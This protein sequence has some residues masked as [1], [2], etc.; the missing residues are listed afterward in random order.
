VSE[1]ASWLRGLLAERLGVAAD[2]I[3][4]EA[5]LNR[6]GLTSLTAA[7]IVT[8][9]EA[10][11]RRRLPPTLAWDYPTLERLTAFLEGRPDADAHVPIVPLAADD[12]IAIVGMAC[13]LPGASSLDDFW[14]LLEAGTDAIREVPADRWPIDQLYDADPLAPGR[15]ATR[16]GGF[17]E[18]VDRFDAAF[19]GLSPREAAQAD[20]QQRLALELAWEA[21]ED[22]AIR[23]SRLSGGRTGVF[24]GAMWSDYAR[25]LSGRD[26]I[27]QHTATGQDISIIS[28]RIAYTLGLQGP[29]LT[30]NTACSSALVAV[31]QAC[32]SLRSG[33]STVALAGGVHLVL[34][35][36]SSIAMTKFGAMAPDGRCKAF[37]SRANGYV[38]GEGGGIVVLKPLSAATRD[39]DRV[40]AVIRGSAVNNDGPS[41]GLTAPN[42]SAQRAMLRDALDSAH[43]H[44]HAVDYVEAHGTGTA[45]GDPIEAN[46]LAAVLGRDRPAGRALRIGSVKTNIGH[47]EAAAGAAGLIKTALALRNRWIP[48]SLHYQAPNPAIDFAAANLEVQSKGGAWPTAAPNPIAGVSSFGFGGTNSHVILQAVEP[49]ATTTS[50]AQA[51]TVFVFAGNGGNWA[52]MARGL[53]Q[54]PVF[55]AA[56]Q[57]C[58]RLLAEL[59]YPQPLLPVLESAQVTD[60]ALGQPALCAFQLALVDLL[61]T[62]GIKP[63]AVIGHSVGEAAAAITSGAL[64]RRD[65]LRLVLER[66]HLQASVAGQGGMALVSAAADAVGRHLPPGVTIAGENGPRATLIAGS[67]PSV[68]AACAV[69]DKAGILSLPIDVPVAYHSAQMD[70]LRP[71]LEQRLRDLKP[72]PAPIPMVSTVTGVATD[73]P[74]LDASYWGRNL[75]EPVRFRQGIETLVAA[76]YRAFVEI[77]AHPLLVP[78]IRQMTPGATVIA[79]LRRDAATSAAAQAALAPLRR[80]VGDGAIPRLLV[81]SARSASALEAL[82]R[83]WAAR[84]PAAW[85]EL[86][87]TAL[88]GRERFAHRLALWSLD[89]ETARRRLQTGDYR[90]GEASP[91]ATIAFDGTPRENENRESFLDRCAE[92]FVAGADLDGLA[93]P[94]SGIT[95]APTYPFERERHWLGAVDRGLSYTVDWETVTLPDTTWPG[96]SVEGDPVDSGLDAEA[97]A[98]AKAALAA[99]PAAEIAP[100]HR[101]LAERFAS[102]EPLA[103][104]PATEGA[105]RDLMRGVGE[106]LPDILAGHVQP[107]EVLFPGGA[108]DRAAAVYES[109]PFAAAQKALGAIIGK[110]GTRPLRI[111]EVGSGTGALTAQLLPSLPPGSTLVCSDLSVAFL[112]HLK[113]RFGDAAALQTTTFDLDKPEGAD[114]PFDAIVAA[115]VLHAT[116]DLD[117]AL[118]ALR[119]RLAPGGLLGLVELQRAPRWIDLVFGITEGWW[120]FHDDPNPRGHAVLDAE[121]WHSRLSAL[122]F[123]DVE[124]R[125]DGDAHAVVLARAPA[126]QRLWRP[127]A[128]TPAVLVDELIAQADD[129]TPLSIVH[130]TSLADAAVAGATRSLSL[131]HPALI[132]RSVELT[133]ESPRALAVLDAVLGLP[134]DEDQVRLTDGV[135]SVPRLARLT[136]AAAEASI[137]PDTLYIVAGGGGRLGQAMT[138]FLIDRGARHL[139][140]VGRSA[141]PSFSHRGVI[142]RSLALD[143]TTADAGARLRAAIDRPLGGLIHAA[144]VADGPTETVLATKLAIAAA[145][146]Q[147]AEGLSLGFLL[148][149]SSAA[150]IWGARGHVAY[151]AANRALDRWAAL[152]RERSVP[153]TSIGFGRFEERGLLSADEDRALQ[154]SG[155]KAMA[156]G[157][158]F[159]AALQAV[160]EGAAHRIVAAVD[161]PLFRATVEARRRRPFF[162]RVAPVETVTAKTVARANAA[163]P[164]KLDRTGLAALVADLLGHADASR[165]DPERGLFEQGLDSLLAVTLRRRLEEATGVAVPAA[166]L[167]AHPTLSLLGDWLGGQERVVPTAKAGARDNNEPIAIIGMGCRFAGGADTPAAYL[168][169]LM[170]GEDMVRQVP[171]TRPTAALWQAVPPTV[172]TAGFLDDVEKFDAAFFGL[173]PR[174]AAQLDP[175]Q[176][177]LLE[178]S[179]HA[180]EDARLSPKELN[181]RRAGV[182]VGATG[183]DYA[184]LARGL[185]GRALDAHS[186]VGQPSNT[187]AGRLAYQFG[188]H[189]PALTVDTACSSSL[190]ALHLAVNALRNGEADLAL[191]GG[192][193]LLLTPD[194]SLMLM[195]AGLLAPD[196]RCKVFDAGANGYVRGEGCGVIVLKPLG[197]ARRDGDRVL[198]VIRG[199]AV[200]HD[201]R[202]SSFTAP[203]GAAQAGVIRDALSNAGVEAESIDCIEAHG[204][205]TQLGDPIELDALADV[206]AGRQRPLLVGSVKAAIGHA[207]A[208][209]G[210]AA[211][212]KTVQSLRAGQLPPQPHFHHRNPHARDGSPV[213]VAA[214]GAVDARFAGV[215]AFGASGTNAHLVIERGDPLPANESAPLLTT[216]NRQVHWLAGQ[217]VASGARHPVLGEPRRSARS[218]ETVWETRLDPNADWLHDHV[219][220]GTILMPAA[221]FLDM[222]RRAG[223]ASLAD[224]EF[225]APLLVPAEGIAVQLV[226]DRETLTLYAETDEDWREIATARIASTPSVVDLPATIDAREID[227]TEIASELTARG[228]AFGP[229]YRTLGSLS[230]DAHHA[231]ATLE[232]VTE[233]EPAMLDAAIQTLTCLLPI[234]DIS[235]LPARIARVD[236]LQAAAAHSARARLL[237]RTPAQ[238][239]GD[240]ALH[241]AAGAPAVVLQGVEL[242]AA[243]AEP[244]AWFHDVLWRP[245]TEDGRALAGRWH[246]IG[247]GAVRP[248]PPCDG[249]VDLRPLTAR[250]PA[251]VVTDTV[252]LVRQALAQTPPP[253]LVLV[254][255]GASTS[256]PTIAQQPSAAAVLMGLQPVIASEHPE[257]S[258][259]WIDLDPDESDLPSDL[260]GE[261]G[262]YAI[263][264]GKLLSPDI[265]KA[266]S[267]P[268]GKIQLVPGAKGSFDDLHVVPAPEKALNAGE[269]R[270]AVSAVGL[271]FKDVLSVIGRTDESRLGLEAVGTVIATAPD[272]RHLATGDSVIAFGS[273]ALASEATFAGNQVVRRPPTLD[274]DTAASVAIAGLT[275]WYGLHDLAAIRPGMQ[276]LIHAG[277]GGVGGM[278]IQIA[279][280]AGARVFAT[281]SRGK[282]RL[283]LLNGAEA[284]G[285]SRSLDFV[286][287]A[288]GWCGPEGFDIV[289]NALGPEIADASARL[290]RP[291]GV[292]LEIGSAPNATG[293]RR[294]FTYDL[295]QAIRRDPNWFVD[296]MSKLLALLRDGK[297]APPRR[298]VLPLALTEEALR[299]LGQGRTVGKL[300]LK[301]PV[302]P[303]IHADASYLVTGGTGD[304]G[305][306]LAGWLKDNG[307]GRVIVLGRRAPKEADARFE[308]VAV[309][310]TDREVL[311]RVIDG[312]PDLKGVIHAAGIVKDGTLAQLDP[313]TVPKVFAPKIDGARH[314]DALTR[315]RVLDF[316][317][318]VSSTA[319]SLASPGQA[320]YASAN[321]WLD[322]L[323][324]AR[325]T[326]GHTATSVAFGPWM[327]GMYA[328]LNAP[329]RAR[330]ERD[331]FRPMAPRRAV[332]AFARALADGA[333]HRLVMDRAADAHGRKIQQDGAARQSLL[334]LPASE[335]PSSLRADLEQRLV[336]LLGFP[337]GTRIEPHR[338]LRDLGLDSLLSVSLRNALAAGYGLDLP[339]TLIFDRP[340]LTALADHLLGLIVPQA[341]PAE[342]ALDTLDAEALAALVERELAAE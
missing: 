332:A 259:R 85:P 274:V 330:L 112:A 279:K 218:R 45:L 269:V 153:A 57:D 195:N 110:L 28:A 166:I 257:L 23:P 38:R 264:Q 169:R 39:G 92:A 230:R 203:N 163:A 91:N 127:A 258:C 222:A 158:A 162:D 111:L 238:A 245:A 178:V 147:A 318:L 309:D 265:V 291:D 197:A 82:A 249:V 311:A 219:V 335:Q 260:D 120:R 123:G 217:A 329:A 40:Y 188:L 282:Q 278:A 280:L 331:G 275:A 134:G 102:W 29:A 86:C 303:A 106:A 96:M 216:F 186:L 101:A 301:L 128:T 124:V 183:S 202:S 200:N 299:A 273:G 44:P 239:T 297:L 47:L 214:G 250:D 206:F 42:P 155:L 179:W 165:L 201:G 62:W 97:V 225:R 339:A 283:A 55:A 15:M 272:V 33:E 253:R 328:A 191:A 17:L 31:H 65:G 223:V 196:G 262:R 234:E 306:A 220:D 324:T 132:A 284:V 117:A 20:P 233:S 35:P 18:S 173:S 336:A 54:E 322:A 208:A 83:H 22:A 319:G 327:A 50:A 154:E 194:T 204:T 30:I 281:A 77:G 193:N 313:A 139:L 95:S 72:S 180:I 187:L 113:Q 243:P 190:V 1:L 271:N 118:R 263:R 312:L 231:T 167:F 157:D 114:G 266:P 26:D 210:I 156:P 75:R 115:N 148:L 267:L 152:A 56:L 251:T 256:P 168:D 268:A 150:A 137:S 242:R 296:R 302:A 323:A 93:D 135:P 192:V 143:L 145:L 174:E 235:M 125:P 342:E 100:R 136:P 340:T 109:A 254:S 185:G 161:W 170:T 84:L 4:P 261:P 182:F 131:T 69:L 333:V 341:A 227:G 99:V 285:D 7:S 71:Q 320:A 19:F 49:P 209:A 53:M 338:A 41:N 276:V 295:D 66:S 175:Q 308:T 286:E 237:Q 326:A 116:A 229:T 107:L 68:S 160:N 277:A 287:A 151:A 211:V 8:A 334:A 159:A 142:A 2:A 129:P 103:G 24:L 184:G 288:R 171:S 221:G 78:Q 207:E 81:L 315:N 255:R 14:H 300:V 232:Q 32:H 88:V 317:V 76:G 16:W 314:L 189:G 252:A 67:K 74:S 181:G 5:R 79:P 61:G 140:L 60:V 307:A 215:S 176:R 94:S 34:A 27:A 248:I 298:T 172:Q 104:P 149:F 224:V 21:L 270:V 292:F 337:A 226:Q 98:Y 305:R 87:R 241:D 316:F 46:A 146:E 141:I 310:V 80:A 25:L 108:F 290:L 43:V 10:H 3:E 325:R 133:D 247:P 293:V 244:G 13:R 294:H 138:R 12:P 246:T 36:E 212:I 144:G 9:I 130:G 177:L 198:G 58:D 105:V 90:R 121:G 236:F 59:G 199:S 11:T 240:A 126:A 63:A 304:V 48:A 213:Q 289:L 51:K 89:G 321:A 64:T 122:G 205:G 70:P 6:Y 73:G 52:G 164:A 119:R 37:D 228:F